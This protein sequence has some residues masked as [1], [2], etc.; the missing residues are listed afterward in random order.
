[1]RLVTYSSTLVLILKTP[2]VVRILK[3]KKLKAVSTLK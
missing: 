1:M 2:L 3:V